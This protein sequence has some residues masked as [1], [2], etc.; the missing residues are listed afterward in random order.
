MRAARSGPFVRI[1]ERAD[2]ILAACNPY[3]HKIDKARGSS[4]QFMAYR[5]YAT[6]S[7]GVVL[8]EKTRD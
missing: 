1:F 8:Q 3:L 5:N 4:I 7:H 6:I 2:N